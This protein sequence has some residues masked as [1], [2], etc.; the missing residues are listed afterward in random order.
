MIKSEKFLKT[1]SGY[2]FIEVLM[3]ITILGIV[4]VPMLSLFVGGYALMVNSGRKT[5]AANL[6]RE[7]IEQVKANGYDYYMNEIDPEGDLEKDPE[8]GAAVLLSEN[9]V[10]G[11][12]FF[13]RETLVEIRTSDVRSDARYFLIRVVVTWDDRGVERSVEM[14][15]ILARR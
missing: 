10:E 7:M 4:V 15:S 9:P 6:C 13:Q 14:E 11:F 1:E 8:D 12:E 5:I 3:A 2:S